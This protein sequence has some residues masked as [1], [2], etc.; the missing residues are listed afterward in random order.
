MGS[1]SSKLEGHV[2]A[3]PFEGT[4]YRSANPDE[5]P[6]VQV[7]DHVSEGEVVCILEAMKLMNEIFSDIDG[8]VDQ[9]LVENGQAV[10]FGQALMIIR[11]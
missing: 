7:R 2:I 9:I 10:E 1:A 11:P 6:L 5:P 4:F 3:S 8:T